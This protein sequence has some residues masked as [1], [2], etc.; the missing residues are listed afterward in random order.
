MRWDTSRDAGAN[1][2][3]DRFS[4]IDARGLERP[5]RR[6]EMATL[7]SSRKSWRCFDGLSVPDVFGYGASLRSIDK[8]PKVGMSENHREAIVTENEFAALVRERWRSLLRLFSFLCRSEPTMWLKRHYMKLVELSHDAET[9]LDDY[10]ARN[11]KAFCYLAEAV[12]SIR[13]LGKA[14]IAL[15]HLENRLDRYRV[16]FSHEEAS[17]FSVETRFTS[18]FLA[19]SVAG[20]IESVHAE[21]RRLGIPNDE[22]AL[23]DD[24]IGE[25]APRFILPHNVDEENVLNEEQKI[26]EVASRYLAVADRVALLSKGRIV[27]EAEL[28]AFVLKNLDEERARSIESQIH[29]IQSKYD[30]FVRMT[31]LESTT[32]VL[33]RLRGHASLALHLL[34]IGV[35]LVH[36][37]VR[38]ENDVRYE[39]AKQ[40][41]SS[42]VKKEQVLDRL[43][44]FALL[45]ASRVLDNG[46]EFA[47]EVLRRF[48]TAREETFELPEGTYL[49]ARPVSLIVR[50]VA[51]YG[52]PVRMHIGGE[53]VNAASIMEM[54]LAVGSHAEER[55]V[56]FTG[57]SRALRDI[58][59][60]FDAGLGERG[61]ATLPPALDYLKA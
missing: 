50:I 45:N 9:F 56:R 17:Q 11:N 58:R 24:K 43:V 6:R 41:I 54:I 21:L 40:R 20:L 28:S 36:F 10:G 33:P 46:R 2:R 26:A 25:L 30:T 53:Q 19:T 44:N 5:A 52:T 16:R 37:Y 59:L 15:K 29:S 14:A 12:A 27:G 18:D 4:T 22:P 38:H 7:G 61:V 23:E 13:G 55:A 39:Q 42:I 47:E 34:E 8:S 32:P 31:S 49:H 60:L 51:H 1:E 48:V 35:E 57:D 3:A